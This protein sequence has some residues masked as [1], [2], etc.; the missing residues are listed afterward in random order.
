MTLTAE[1]GREAAGS[2]PWLLGL[3]AEIPIDGGGRRAARLTA[4][5]LTALQALYDYG[6]AVWTART[7][8]ERARVDLALSTDAVAPAER[9][10]QARRGRLQRLQQRVAAGEDARPA[11]LLAET[12][13]AAAD[14][15]GDEARGR[16][17]A[18]LADLAAALNLD[19]AAA[20][21]LALAPP[22]EPGGLD[23]LPAWRDAAALSRGDV[24]RAV[25]DYDLAEAALRLEVARQYPELR[26]GPG[27]TWDRGVTKL[28]FNLNLVLPPRDLNRSGIAQAE[29]K[30]MEA[31]RALEATQAAVLAAVDRASAA[32]ANARSAA[33]LANGA[34]LSA[35]RSS[36]DVVRRAVEAGEL[37]R[38][39]QLQAEAQ[40]AEAEL[41]AA[42]AKRAA[43][44][45]V[46]DLEDALHRSFDPA[47][48]AVLTA[49]L[50]S[51]S[52]QP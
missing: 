44:L 47:Q 34:G 39:D 15:R 21:A 13:L 46:V 10:I 20:T 14:R 36:V 33:A 32:L 48:T 3:L 43:R 22:D 28:P 37:D 7:T 18:A 25:A 16:R 8:L 51:E 12:E 42:E 35:A 30:R 41:A 5:D 50:R 17:A 9:A 11:S 45:A 49:A 40:A 24:E 31:G 2:S 52:A 4:A 19:P 27:Y 29:A 23:A 38:T 1:Y 6:E 26:I